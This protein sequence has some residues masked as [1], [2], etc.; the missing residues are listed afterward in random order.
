MA[1]SHIEEDHEE[2]SAHAFDSIGHSAKDVNK[3]SLKSGS[4]SKFPGGVV[5]NIGVIRLGATN[6]KDRHAFKG[7]ATERHPTANNEIGQNFT[8]AVDI[9]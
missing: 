4:N 7:I 2:E 8:R 5:Y 1:T 9:Q 3:K 6:H